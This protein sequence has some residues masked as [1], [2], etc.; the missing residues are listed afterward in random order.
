MNFN[1][2][3]VKQETYNPE[4]QV[5]RSTQTVEEHNASTEAKPE[6]VTVGTNLP[7]AALDAGPGSR[8]SGARTEEATNY[9]IS[10]TVRNLVQEGD[11]KSG[12]EGKSESL[13]VDLGGRRIIKKKKTT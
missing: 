3:V 8:T 12:E 6:A 1:H 2:E 13:R 7:D 9:E 10:K 5:V 4:G 11:R